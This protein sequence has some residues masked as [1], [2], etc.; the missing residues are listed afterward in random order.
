VNLHVYPTDRSWFD[1]LSRRS[2]VDE[3]NFWLPGGS[4]VWRSLAPG[5]LL[6]FRLKSPVNKIAGGG[7]FVHFSI[8]PLGLAWEAFGTKNGTDTFDEF[9]SKIARFK[10]VS[11][12]LLAADATIGCIILQAPFFLPAS[13]WIEVPSDFPLN[14]VQGKRYDTTTGTGRTLLNALAATVAPLPNSRRVSEALPTTPTY[15]EPALAKRRLGQGAFRVLVTDLYDRRCAVTG[16][17]T[18][19]VLQAA[20]IVPVSKGGQH[21]ADNGL[22]FRSDIH[23]LFDLGYVTVT[24]DHQFLVGEALRDKY[25]NGRVY[26]DLKDRKLRMP[27]SEDAKPCRE[28]LEWHRDTIFRR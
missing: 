10:G 5:E 12:E 6:L 2:D 14:A 13:A 1:F 16:E 20:H 22:L 23:T 18:L 25:S 28:F 4:R 19:P 7:M 26:Y 15:G 21:R 11:P 24:P 3:V 9:R 8:Y 17:R 27:V